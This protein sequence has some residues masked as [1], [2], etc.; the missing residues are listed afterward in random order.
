MSFALIA[1]TEFVVNIQPLLSNEKLSASRLLI[2][3]DFFIF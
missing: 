1:I 3:Y 2:S